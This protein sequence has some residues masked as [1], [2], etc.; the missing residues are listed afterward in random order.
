MPKHSPYAEDE[1]PR[2]FPT[3]AEVESKK[4][5]FVNPADLPIAE[6]AKIR[7]S[8]L[9]EENKIVQRVHVFVR[10]VSKDN[11]YGTGGVVPMAEAESELQFNWLNNGW[12]I[13]TAFL[14]GRNDQL[15]EM[16]FVLTK[17]E[18]VVP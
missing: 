12:R 13:V 5:E 18:V 1:R 10:T 9:G 14:V 2:N 4:P 6:H 17:D 11:T 3:L 8:T 7:N 15:L 16:C